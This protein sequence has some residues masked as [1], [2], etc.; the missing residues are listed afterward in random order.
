MSLYGENT[1]PHYDIQK[2]TIKSYY[3]DEW[4]IQAFSTV[5]AKQ[6]MDLIANLY[7][8]RTQHAPSKN[9]LNKM[10]EMKQNIISTFIHNELNH[11]FKRT[12]EK[13]K[14]KFPTDLKQKY[15]TTTIHNFNM[16]FDKFIKEKQ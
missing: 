13:W 3:G 4:E 16:L 10:T 9:V 8:L 5:L 1:K 2:R 6:S 7:T 14:E 11:F 15:Y 12:E